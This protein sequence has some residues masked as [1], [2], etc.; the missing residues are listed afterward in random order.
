MKLLTVITVLY[1]ASTASSISCY[2]GRW[3]HDERNGPWKT[4][5][6]ADHTSCHQMV[7]DYKDVE[8]QIE[9]GCG[10]CTNTEDYSCQSCDYHYCN[11]EGDDHDSG[12]GQIAI[13]AL[14]VLVPTVLLY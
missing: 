4:D 6:P 9:W 14:S 12:A 2:S 5:C 13:S 11:Y 3:T 1:L 10:S 8:V 7:A